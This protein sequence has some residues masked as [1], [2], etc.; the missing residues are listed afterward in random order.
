MSQE[1]VTISKALYDKTIAVMNAMSN[2]FQSLRQMNAN[3]SY[4]LTALMQVLAQ[5]KMDLT[6]LPP[7]PMPTTLD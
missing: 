4:Q 6:T 2:E 5:H 7:P 3:M 1:T